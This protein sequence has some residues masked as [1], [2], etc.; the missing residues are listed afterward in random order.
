MILRAYFGGGG[1]YF[2]SSPQLSN[3]SARLL[4][5]RKRPVHELRIFLKKIDPAAGYF[6]I[7]NC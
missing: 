7:F 5:F 1:P 2:S 4:D 6:E 3:R